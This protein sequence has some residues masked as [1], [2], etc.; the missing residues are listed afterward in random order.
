M[1]ETSDLRRIVDRIKKSDIIETTVRETFE[2]FLKRKKLKNRNILSISC[3]D[4]T[5]DY[6]CLK[7]T[8][9]CQLTATDIVDIP[10]DK[11]D[12]KLL[13]SL[14]KWNFVKVSPENA[15]PFPDNRFDFIFHFDVIEHVKKP[16]SFLLEQLRL[17]KPGGQILI[18]TPNLLRPANVIKHLLGKLN[19]PLNIGSNK[20]IGEYIHIQEFTSWGLKNILKELGFK[21]II[22]KMVYLG[23]P[24]LK[25]K[26]LKHPRLFAQMSHSIFIYA[27]K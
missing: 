17:L 16:Y 19:F 18:V 2:T 20:D 4:G 21:K 5:W 11:K 14:G 15:Y 23:I 22:V 3:G 24:L 10:V 9:N 1:A 26:I 12:V 13:K 6:V 27:S 25:I 7:N 8:S